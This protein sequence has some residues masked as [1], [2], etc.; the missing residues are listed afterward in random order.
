MTIFIGRLYRQ[1]FSSGSTSRRMATTLCPATGTRT[2]VAYSGARLSPFTSCSCLCRCG[3]EGALKRQLVRRRC[4]C[5]NLSLWRFIMLCRIMYP[6]SCYHCALVSALFCAPG[7][8][9][10]S[11]LTAANTTA[12]VGCLSTIS[13][14]AQKNTVKMR[15]MA[16]G[17]GLGSVA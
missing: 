12:S 16:L 15:E 6:V 8:A 2:Q 13:R 7:V 4:T 3:K 10:T 11:S 5:L 14:C 9:L 17:L 1:P